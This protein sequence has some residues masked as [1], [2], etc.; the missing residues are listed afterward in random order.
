MGILQKFLKLRK[1]N[2]VVKIM[3]FFGVVSLIF[4]G[5]AINH[6]FDLH[7]EMNSTAEYILIG[8]GRKSLG[9]YLDEL[10]KMEDI[11]CVS[12]QNE[13]T[14]S[15]Y[16]QGKEISM[17]CVGISEDYL[18]A[19]Y[20]LEDISAMQIFYINDAFK[21]ELF[22]EDTIETMQTLEYR[23]DEKN[24]ENGIA[25]IKFIESFSDD[26]NVLICVE[27]QLN[28]M[29]E[30]SS[31]RIGMKKNRLNVNRIKQWN[32]MGLHIENQQEIEMT[33]VQRD[34]TLQTIKYQFIIS[35]LCLLFVV[36]LIKYGKPLVLKEI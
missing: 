28:L 30:A 16:I 5:T 27:N 31:L 32:A 1:Q 2:D 19:M 18:K 21:K 26:V 22:G 7:Q 24:I 9:N 12:L 8:N 13:S 20:G 11:Q 29:D 4:F 17:E 33:A 35:G 23:C 6:L 34:K 10:S 15:F 36:F 3:M 14:V 25:K